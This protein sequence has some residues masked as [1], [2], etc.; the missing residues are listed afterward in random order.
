[1]PSLVERPLIEY[2][3]PTYN[4]NGDRLSYLERTITNLLAIDPTRIISVLE[5]PDLDQEGKPLSHYDDVSNLINQLKADNPCKASDIRYFR[6]TE[7]QMFDMG[8]INLLDPSII[9]VKGDIIHLHSDDDI[10][11]PH[12]PRT[13]KDKYYDNP[14][15]TFIMCNASM[16]QIGNE[17]FD[18]V[19]Q[20]AQ[21]MEDQFYVKGSEFFF[22]PTSGGRESYPF[23]EVG[24]LG[25]VAL[26][27][28]IDFV[29]PSRWN[30]SVDRIKRMKGIIGMNMA[31]L[32]IIYDMIALHGNVT[33]IGNVLMRILTGN[34]PPWGSNVWADYI[35]FCLPYITL[36]GMDNDKR[37]NVK[38]VQKGISELRTKEYVESLRTKGG[39]VNT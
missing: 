26:N 38:A 13:V 6:H 18:Y 39:S 34:S 20:V 35:D 21:E 25:I 7:R 10:A 12:M 24:V 15:S 23:A 17:D 32:F 8:I 14:N 11:L 30:Q 27:M 5:D 22:T 2:R 37:T 3:I 36:L 9:P 29:S 16:R 31:H 19:P 28:S 1:M 4:G 33:T